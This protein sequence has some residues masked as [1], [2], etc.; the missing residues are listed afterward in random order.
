[1][2]TW[3]AIDTTRAIR[4]FE[5]RP[6]EPAHLQRIL[7]AGRLPRDYVAVKF[8]AAQSLPDT[9]E[10]RRT[11]AGLVDSL[12]ERTNVVLPDTGRTVEEHR[13]LALDGTTRAS[14]VIREKRGMAAARKRGV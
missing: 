5:D 1:M 14:R 4:K 9:P 6:L 13:D 7:D 3:Q 10:I 12:A 2:D 8:Y 11:P